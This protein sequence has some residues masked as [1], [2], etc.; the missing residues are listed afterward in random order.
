[1]TTLVTD[2]VRGGVAG[3]AQEPQADTPELSV[4]IPVKERV[5]DVPGTLQEYRSAL[6]Q[7]GVTFE[8]IFVLDGAYPLVLNQIRGLATP[9]SGMTIIAMPRAFGEAT[10]ISAGF[11]HSRGRYVL[12][13]PA[14]RQVDAR[15]LPAL[16]AARESADML[17]AN[18]SPRRDGFVNRLQTRV[19][20]GIASWISG[21]KLEDA[22]CNVRLMKR[23]VLEEVH[24][25]GDFHRFIPMLAHRQGFL[26]R[27]HDMAQA[28][29]DVQ[30]R[31][32]KPGL[33]IRRLLD[34]LTMYFLLRFTKKPFRFFGLIGTSLLLVGGLI[35]A[36]LVVE[37][38]AGQTALADRPAFVL[39]TLL[40]VFG[41]QLF[42][43]GL[44]GEI[45]IF[46]HARELKEYSIKQIIGSA[47][48]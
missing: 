16:I 11:E 9:G 14:Y 15:D 21:L 26:I 42:S 33:Y 17:V 38:L 34:L 39:G 31:V 19:F 30:N 12:L 18:R 23:D 46:S 27:H 43:V 4:I 2:V 35:T 25:Y 29:S 3:A 44:I 7:S 45:I 28:E 36:W 37:R 24:L 41:I 13:L 48:D 20:S 22:G 40:M 1:M 5:D 8:I 47:D 10:A 32:Y 6:L